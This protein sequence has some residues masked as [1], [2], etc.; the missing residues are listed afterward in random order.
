M[1]SPSATRMPLGI[2]WRRALFRSSTSSDAWR[3][4]PVTRTT[5][6]ASSRRRRSTTGLVGIAS[7]RCR[8]WAS[9]RR[10]SCRLVPRDS[11]RPTR[12]AR[13]RATG[14]NSPARFRRPR[15]RCLVRRLSTPA[16]A[17]RGSALWARSAT[18]RTIQATSPQPSESGRRGAGPWVMPEKRAWRSSSSSTVRSGRADS[19]VARR[20]RSRQ[21]RPPRMRCEPR[22]RAQREPLRATRTAAAP[23][24][25]RQKGR[26]C[27]ATPE[28][29]CAGPG[30]GRARRST[31]PR[32]RAPFAAAGLRHPWDS[33]RAR[34][35]PPRSRLR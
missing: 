7:S 16:P 23:R 25:G 3:K 28:D 34:P 31:Q 1:L 11:R 14:S 35:Q 13:W 33:E 29:G 18:P 32:L 4:V 26:A 8:V 17:Y 22:G 20:R 9:A 10:A 2:P 19:A 30:R 21:F 5:S 15:I 24:A 27:R 6:G 12:R